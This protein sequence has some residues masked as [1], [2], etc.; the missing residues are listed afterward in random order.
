[1]V[2]DSRRSYIPR[3]GVTLTPRENTRARFSSFENTITMANLHIIYTAK[4][5]LE[6]SNIQLLVP[7]SKVL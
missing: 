2:L 4:L 5:F 1:M 6:I 7:M 3:I